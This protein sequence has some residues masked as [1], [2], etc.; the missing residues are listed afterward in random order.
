MA[1]TATATPE[2]AREI[3]ERLR[4]RDARTFIASFDRPNIQYRIEAKVDPRRQLVSF[5]RSQ[6]EGSAGIVYALSRKS[7]EQTAAY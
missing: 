4:L 7:V 3:V 1:L 6:S 2:T 5:I